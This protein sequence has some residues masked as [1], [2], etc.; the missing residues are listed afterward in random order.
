MKAAMLLRVTSTLDL[1]NGYGTPVRRIAFVAYWL[2]C[3]VLTES[4][5]DQVYL[6]PLA[7]QLACGKSHAVGAIFL[8]NLFNHLDALHTF[9][10]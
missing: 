6:I 3:Y 1:P 10:I 7:V 4:L 2:N 9:E 5:P 8:S